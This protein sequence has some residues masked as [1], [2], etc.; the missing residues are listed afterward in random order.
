MRNK[1]E[2]SPIQA[3]I[4]RYLETHRRNVTRAELQKD[5]FGT[6]RS[7]NNDRMIQRVI[8]DLR[9]LGFV[10]V[11]QSGKPGYKLTN[12]KAEISTYVNEQIARGKEAIKTARRGAKAYGLRGQMSLAGV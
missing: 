7:R 8:H 11:S 10:I 2:L 3:R 12:N 5:V 4:L 6:T 9:M 1:T